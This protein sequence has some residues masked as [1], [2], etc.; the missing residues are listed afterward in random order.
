MVRINSQ[1]VKGNNQLIG[2]LLTINDWS[3]DSL[4]TFNWWSGNDQSQGSS[5][6]KSSTNFTYKVYK[7][8]KI[9]GE[10]FIFI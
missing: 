5:I 1:S 2:Q 7:M 6:S 4:S 9:S 8:F 3:I 10:I